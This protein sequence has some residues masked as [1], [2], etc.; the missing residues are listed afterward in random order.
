MPLPST[1]VFDHPTAR[2][3]A[4]VLEPSNTSCTEQIVSNHDACRD[5]RYISVSGL[6]VMMPG[7]TNSSLAA[8]CMM[9]CGRDAIGAVPPAR[10]SASILPPLTSLV[11]SRVRH[12]GFMAGCQLLDN[13]VFGVSAA[14]AAAMDPQQRLL[15][16]RGYS[17]LQRAGLKRT[18]VG[19][20]CCG[21]FLGIASTE[22]AQVLATSP[23]GASV[24]AATGSALSVASGRLS[25]V[26]GLH[27]PCSAYD[28]ACSAALVACHGGMRALQLNECVSGVVAGIS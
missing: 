26:L 9:S 18:I 10:W 17:A 15:L 7:K 20:S 22:F 3:L 11:A 21:V 13:A 28:T 2:Q 4:A 19:G 8:G 24:Y 1:L 6:S 12:G 5:Y 14:E 23:A 16:E 27:G 25:Y